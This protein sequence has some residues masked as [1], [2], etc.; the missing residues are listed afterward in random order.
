MGTT[1][2]NSLSKKIKF[3]RKSLLR[4][5]KR[6]GR[7]FP[8]RNEPISEYEIVIAEL[9]LQR[10]RAETVA[11][12]Y[13]KFINQFPSWSYL[14]DASHTD[15]EQ[16]L[17][18]I[19]LWQR[20]ASTLKTL[21]EEIVSKKNRLPDSKEEIA[22]LP[23]IGQY[24]TNAILLICRGHKVPLL[25]GNMARVLERFFGQRKLV[26]IRYD[27]YLQELSKQ[28]V[29]CK[30]SKTIN[31]AILDFA[32]LVCKINNPSCCVCPLSLKCKILLCEK[33]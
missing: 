7:V 24:I 33:Q 13:D 11:I 30:D 16:Y 21:A 26:D 12:Y 14:H 1:N 27:P 8:W 9:L 3:F 17:K 10:T 4:W 5:Y 23:G 32:P 20:R 31:W 15:L 6:N 29:N 2:N 22:L 25:D 19:G 28:V 18:P